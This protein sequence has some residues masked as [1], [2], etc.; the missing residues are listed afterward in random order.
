M[1]SKNDSILALWSIFF[2]FLFFI[3]GRFLNKQFIYSLHLNLLDF[4]TLLLVLFETIQEINDRLLASLFG[5]AERIPFFLILVPHFHPE[6][7][8]QL[9]CVQPPV[10]RRVEQ[11]GLR[12]IILVVD[13]GAVISER[14]NHIAMALAGCVEDWG[15]LLQAVQ[16]VCV[17][18]V[19]VEQVT[20]NVG[21]A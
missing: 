19:L 3:M 15:L 5:E 11:T 10:P 13:V 18:V 9:A 21:V 2:H 17:Q 8:Q 4:P 7:H 6:R 12:I 14:L 16:V 1:I 20:S